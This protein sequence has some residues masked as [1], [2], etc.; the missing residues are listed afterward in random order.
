MS[1]VPV[2]GID[3]G[4]VCCCVAVFKDKVEIVA[5]NRGDKTTPSYVAFTDKGRLIGDSAKNQVAMNPTNTIFDVKRMIGRR[6]DDHSVLIDK[7]HWPFEVIDEGSRLKVRVEFNGRMRTFFPEEVSSTVLAKMKET[8]ESYLGETVTNAV[9]SVPAYFND[10]QRVATKDAGTI[11]GLN[12]LRLINEPSAAAIAYGLNKNV[13]E[14]QNV[15]I[16]D[17]GGGTF[18]VSILTIEDKV[19]EV[20]S[21]AGNTHLGGEDFD[22]RMV[23]YFIQEFMRKYSKD[24]GQNKKS[25]ARLKTACEQAKIALSSVTEASIEINSLYEDIDFCTKITRAIFE[26]IND[27]LFGSILKPVERAL[28]DSNFDKEQIDDIVL[29]GG[30]TRIPKI[31]KLLQDF[32]NGKELN[33]SFDLDESIAYGAAILAANIHGSK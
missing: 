26:E 24:M 28:Q 19:F 23:D 27:D 33:S 2:V 25:V 14:G 7:K 15:L 6:T 13:E 31:Q 11:A 12:V 17:L 16:F 10:S 29:V 8:V 32:F 3:L 18:D 22:N 9:I 5:N 30:S 20:R 4:T 21:T 1:K